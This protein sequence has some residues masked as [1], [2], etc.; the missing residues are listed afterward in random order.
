MKIT[1]TDRRKYIPL[2]LL[3][4]LL[5]CGILALLMLAGARLGVKDESAESESHS[6]SESELYDLPVVIIDAGHGGEDGGTVGKNGA[7]E[8]DINLSVALRLSDSLKSKGIRTVLTRSEDVLLYDKNSDYQGQ[9][10][11]QDLAT[12]K[13]IAEAYDDAIFVSI[14]MNSFPDERYSGLQVYYSTND[15]SSR[16][17]AESL[18]SI[19]RKELMPENTR[20]CKEGDDIYLLN[21]LCCPAVLVEC[22]FLSNPDECDKLCTEE[23]QERLADTLAEAIEEFIKS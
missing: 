22:G 21:R 1:V 20:Q 11:V 9:K 3:I 14:H 16:T 2:Y 12:R 4:S 5:L 13:R 8:K 6:E 17:L 18:Q 23:Y 7:Y 15:E 10:K 19:T